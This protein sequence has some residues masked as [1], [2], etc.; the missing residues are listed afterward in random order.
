MPPTK[1]SAAII[2]NQKSWVLKSTTVELS[3]TQKAGHM[4]PV[5]FDRKKCK[6]QPYSIAPWHGEKLSSDIPPLLQTLR[7]DF[8]CLPFG[9][10]EKPFKGKKFLPHGETANRAWKLEKILEE[11]GD[12]VLHVSQNQK[13]LTGGRVDKILQLK[14]GHNAVYCRHIIKGLSGSINF[15]HHATLK[16]PDSPDSGLISTSPFKYG[17]VYPH[18]FEKPESGGY[19]SLQS[20][21]SF[22]TLSQVP[23]ATGGFTDLSRYP[24]RKGYE[25]IVMMASDDR[26]PFAWTAVS[27]PKEGY[28]WFALKDPRILRQTVFWISNGGRHYAPWNGRHTAVMGLE[29]V[30]T[31]YGAGIKES[32]MPNSFS[33]RGY[34][35]NIV[36]SPKKPYTVNYIMGAISTPKGFGKVSAITAETDR[37]TLHSGKRHV[38]TPLDI[39]FLFLE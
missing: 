19:N 28:V 25:D 13:D 4:A 2:F 24:A 34:P 20:G 38:S 12:H 17:E 6:I 21:S 30:T 14:D 3:L 36:L 39:E 22:K 5:I 26:L 31:Y 16:F 23:L 1:K 8:F 32:C 35:T 37:I 18:G 29:E 33:R 11:G 27:F 7:G 15:G 10:N 9:G